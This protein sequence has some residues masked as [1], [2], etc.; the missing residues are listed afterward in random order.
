MREEPRATELL[1][2]VA[3]FLRDEVLPAL[4][5]R[6]AFHARVAANVLDI[7]R[8]ELATGDAAAAD[9][10]ARLAALL[11]REGDA[12][13]LNAELCRGLREGAFAPDDPALLAHLWATTLATVAID[14]PQ[15][16]TY[17][18]AAAIARHDND[19]EH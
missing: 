14:Q 2:A 11:G 17:R 19:G 13:T 10:R 8:R 6:L 5:G 16:E 3:A 4:D 12:A 18:R 9:E 7:V 15:Y 1:D